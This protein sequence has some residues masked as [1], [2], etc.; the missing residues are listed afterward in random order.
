MAE[1]SEQNF[2]CRE[3]ATAVMDVASVVV[4]LMHVLV[5]HRVIPVQV[6]HNLADRISQP[7]QQGYERIGRDA[8]HHIAEL[9]ALYTTLHRLGLPR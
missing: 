6:A 4:E 8:G 9:A 1:S 5:V 7:M 3:V 2:D